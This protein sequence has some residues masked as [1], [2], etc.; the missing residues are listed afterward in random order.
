VRA[1]V[2]AALVLAPSIALADDGGDAGDASDDASPEGIQ[3][4]TTSDNLGCS[5]SGS[6]PDAAWLLLPLAI[7]GLRRRR[8]LAAAAVALVP[9]TAHA[10]VPPDELAERAPEMRRFAVYVNPMSFIVNRY[11]ASIEVLLASHHAL[12][13]GAYYVYSEV[14]DGVS[15]NV[16]RGV[17]G[18]LGYRFYLGQNGFRGFYVG[19]SLLLAAL[20]AVPRNGASVSYFDFG[21]ALDLGWE[22]LVADRV[23]VG[24]GAGAQYT[25]NT[26]TLPPQQ[27]PAS[28]Y[29][30]DGIRPRVSIAIGVAF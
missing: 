25:T 24:I 27:I 26:K 15:N 11:G 14:S 5:Q 18:E 17:G 22:A 30:N 13:A 29:A 20:E 7:F 9:A 16:F 19:P 1:A 4:T 23:L 10:Q 2:V 12:E 6:R 28:V 3:A 21:G 8:A